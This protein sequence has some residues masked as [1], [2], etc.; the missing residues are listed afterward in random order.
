MVNLWLSSIE[1]LLHFKADFLLTFLV[2]T[3]TLFLVKYEHF[4]T[5]SWLLVGI[6]IKTHFIWGR[7]GGGLVNWVERGLDLTFD[8]AKTSEESGSACK[9]I[10]LP[11]VTDWAHFDFRSIIFMRHGWQWLTE[12]DSNPLRLIHFQLASCCLLQQCGKPCTFRYYKPPFCILS[13]NLMISWNFQTFP[14]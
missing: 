5:L 14:S 12:A 6:F 7:G 10:L 8:P 11:E 13:N 4:W 2:F 1:L 9:K 3:S